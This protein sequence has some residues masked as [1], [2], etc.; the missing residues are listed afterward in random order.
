MPSLHPPQAAEAD[1]AE[2]PRHDYLAPIPADKLT[3][4]PRELVAKAVAALRAGELEAASSFANQ[5]LAL[6]IDNSYLQFCN[7]F[8][9]HQMAIDGDQAKSDLAIVGYGL[10]VQFDPTNWLARYQLELLHLE[11]REWD[12]AQQHL[13]E[14]LHYNPADPGVL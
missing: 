3:S 2:R 10:A 12:V 1:L 9:Y 5:A 11:R 7:A 13:G 14:A 4:E 8:V 6:E